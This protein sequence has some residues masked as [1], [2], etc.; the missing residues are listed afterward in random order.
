MI[1]VK[2]AYRTAKEHNTKKKGKVSGCCETKK[3][4]YFHFG[5]LLYGDC[6]EKV[7]K[8]TGNCETI[9]S[10]TQDTE[11]MVKGKEIPIEEFI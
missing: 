10:S 8:K 1:D 9:G 2:T 5:E 11:D 4:F 3:Y 7:D 6:L